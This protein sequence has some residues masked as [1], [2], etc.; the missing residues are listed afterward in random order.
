MYRHAPAHAHWCTCTNTCTCTCECTARLTISGVRTPTH[1]STVRA[2]HNHRRWTET[3]GDQG[4]IGALRIRDTSLRAHRYLDERYFVTW[5]PVP[6]APSWHL[7]R[8]MQWLLETTWDHN[9]K[10]APESEPTV[11]PDTWS[12]STVL[13]P[14][15]NYPVQ[16]NPPVI[17]IVYSHLLRYEVW[18]P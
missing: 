7:D 6:G 11:I 8:R 13:P 17:T 15:P 1:L 16:Q 12:T 9:H 2:H 4:P 3:G 14:D 18:N 5:T 10:E